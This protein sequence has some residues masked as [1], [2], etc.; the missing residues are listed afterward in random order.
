MPSK[1][2]VAHQLAAAGPPV[3]GARFAAGLAPQQPGNVVRALGTPGIGNGAVAGSGFPQ[4]AMRT[5]ALAPQNAG[6]AVWEH[7]TVNVPWP[8][9]PTLVWL[10]A[11]L[12][13]LQLEQQEATN[14]VRRPGNVEP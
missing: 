9:V 13:M 5:R 3:Q 4:E 2:V 11:L 10:S 8:H 12:A 7:I 6:N 14:A 1:L